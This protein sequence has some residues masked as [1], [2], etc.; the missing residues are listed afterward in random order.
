MS[1]RSN[2]TP[3]TPDAP[4]LIVQGEVGLPKRTQREYAPHPSTTVAQRQPG[5][6]AHPVP[7]LD[8]MAPLRAVNSTGKDTPT[9]DV[10]FGAHGRKY[11][12]P[13]DASVGSRHAPE[14][15]DALLAEAHCN[16][17]LPGEKHHSMT[18][19]KGC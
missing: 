18:G 1:N 8:P 7:G 4:D 16:N 19:K 17:M 5:G 14:I 10:T 9:P 3:N 6:R 2:P 13:G 11:S 12:A 15:G